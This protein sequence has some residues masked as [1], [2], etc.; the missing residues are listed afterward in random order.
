MTRVKRGTTAHQRHKKTL[1]LAKG[2]SGSRH[3]LWKMANETVMRGLAYAYAHRRTRKRDFHRLW[4]M[5]INA[6]ARME[7]LSYSQLMHGINTAGIRIDRKILADL[8]VRDMDGFRA[9]VAQA[10]AALPATA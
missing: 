10:R 7:G 8:A 2:Y 1:E 6:A 4:I 9:V 3:R 5:R